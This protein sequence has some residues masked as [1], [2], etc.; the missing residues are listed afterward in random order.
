ME[1]LLEMLSTVAHKLRFRNKKEPALRRVPE[2][3]CSY[4]LE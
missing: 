4:S 3:V 2:T 1:K